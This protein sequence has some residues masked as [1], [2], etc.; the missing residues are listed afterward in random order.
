MSGVMV[1]GKERLAT[2][3]YSEFNVVS[4]TVASP[5]EFLVGILIGQNYEG[6]GY[7]LNED[8]SLMTAKLP[9]WK[10]ESQVSEVQKEYGIDSE[11]AFGFGQAKAHGLSAAYCIGLSENTPVIVPIKDNAAATAVDSY[12]ESNEDSA[13]ELY[14][15]AITKLGQS[16]TG[17]GQTLKSAKFYLKKTGTPTGNMTVSLFA[18]SGSFGTTSVGT[19]VALATSEAVSVAGLTGSYALTE[20][21]FS[22]PYVLTNATK[23]VIAIEFVGTSDISNYLSVGVDGSAPSHAGNPATYSGTMWTYDATKDVCFYVYGNTPATV[24]TLTSRKRGARWGDTRIKILTA[25][26]ANVFTITP[27]K[28]P[29]FALANVGIGDISLQVAVLPSWLKLGASVYVAS[30]DAAS[31]VATVL[32]IIENKTT[33]VIGGETVQLTSSF[34]ITFAAALGSAHTVANNARIYQPDTA[35]QEVSSSCATLQNC[36]DWFNTTS[37]YFTSVMEDGAV[38]EPYT[39]TETEAKAFAGATAATSPAP[40]SSSITNL[41]TDLPD[42]INRF[43][44]SEALIPRLYCVLW[45]THT[46]QIKLRDFAITQRNA[47]RPID[48]IVGGSLVAIDTESVTL[49]NNPKMRCAA[50]NCEDV[51]LCIGGWDGQA[52]YK[53]FAPA[54]FGAVIGSPMA[55]NLTGDQLYFSVPQV[56]WTEDLGGTMDDILGAGAMV[57]SVDGGYTIEKGQ[58]SLQ[59]QAFWNPTT[60]RTYLRMQR[61]LADFVIINFPKDV[62]KRCGG[63]T[64]VEVSKTDVSVAGRV[65]LD[66]Y[67]T[68]GAIKSGQVL[69]V[70]IDSSNEGWRPVIGF[71]L[72]GERNYIVAELNLIVALQ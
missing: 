7:D 61:T 72:P 14:A 70:L 6:N 56:I 71:T 30:N 32:S 3:G 46:D 8:I 28:Q 55:H 21:T 24:M 67:V 38:T 25:D 65:V 4:D 58:N 26:G 33:Y 54:V 19:G 18:H 39:I 15:G 64:D 51:T 41:I 48:V 2:G 62:Y 12:I 66:S 59:E 57:Y 47:G 36:I 40:T 17:N 11:L 52:A 31:E 37:E 63:T 44:L 23:Y 5:P 53:T 27:P 13:I 69:D 29:V 35:L 49:E 42:I 34:T 20:F 1:N 68:R 50:L 16:F 60:K 10:K 9:D 43:K 22:T 45:G